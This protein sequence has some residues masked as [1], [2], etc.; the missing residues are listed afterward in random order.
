M[1]TEDGLHLGTL[2]VMRDITLEVEADNL[3]DAFITSISHELRTPLTVI[4]VYG[5]LMQKTANGQLDDRQIQFLR[6]INRSTKQ[7][8]NHINQLINISEIQAGTIQINLEELDIVKLVR[9]ATENWQD[10]FSDKGIQFKVNLPHNPLIISADKTQLQWAVESLLSNAHNYT[11]AGGQVTIILETVSNFVQLNV[12]D[13][14]IGIA[15]ADQPKLFNRFFRVQNSINY[16]TRGV[17]LGLFIA[18]SVVESHHGEIS[19]V[20]ELGQG[21]TFTMMLP[22]PAMTA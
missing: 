6:N 14:G 20:S 16:E 13:T 10:R 11:S 1:A 9:N 8:E 4:K 22:L 18:K 12:I 15:A 7:L 5:D 19:V 2:I 17:G 3:K 21:S